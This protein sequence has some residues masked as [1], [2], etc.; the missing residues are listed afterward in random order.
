MCGKPYMV[1]QS[2]CS[3]IISVSKKTL[4]VWDA[5]RPQ[6]RYYHLFQHFRILTIIIK[7]HFRLRWIPPSPWVTITGGLSNRNIGR[8]ATIIR[9]RICEFGGFSCTGNPS[10]V[11][12]RTHEWSS[13][14]LQN[15]RNVC[16]LIFEQEECPPAPPLGNPW[17]L[18]TVGILRNLEI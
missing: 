5:H 18:P 15:V 10:V 16:N 4:F 12:T 13:A 6:F 17:W 7:D 3:I 14:L 8:G 2:R 11:E 9:F 1:G